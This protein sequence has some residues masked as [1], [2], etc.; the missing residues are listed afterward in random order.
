MEYIPA[1]FVLLMALTLLESIGRVFF[2]PIAYR[3]G[4]RV[5]QERLHLWDNGVPLTEDADTLN[6]RLKT[7]GDR[8]LMRRRWRP[9]AWR[10]NVEMTG[11][12]RFEGSECLVE[13]R[14]PLTTFI[15]MVVWFVGWT[16]GAISGIAS[17]QRDWLLPALFGYLVFAVVVWVTLVSGRNAMSLIVREYLGAR[18]TS[19]S[20]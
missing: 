3:F 14:I 4:P 19:A 11:S 5:F 16:V 1:A 15:F 7:R 8:V 6:G 2:W 13:V 20:S 18:L 12:L 9:L 17:G 10:T